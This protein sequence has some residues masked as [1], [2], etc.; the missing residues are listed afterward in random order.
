MK[1]RTIPLDDLEH[2][3]ERGISIVSSLKWTY[4]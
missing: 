3:M 2:A 1:Y 4:H